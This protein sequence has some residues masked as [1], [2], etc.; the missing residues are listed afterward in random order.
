MWLVTPALL[1]GLNAWGGWSDLPATLHL[2]WAERAAIGGGL[3]LWGLLLVEL[4]VSAPI[5]VRAAVARPT[6]V[7][8]GLILAL[9]AVAAVLLPMWMITTLGVGALCVAAGGAL[10]LDNI[11]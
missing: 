8:V 3:L 10:V 1:F 5:E 6:S 11:R 9:G 7:K 2:Y 4:I